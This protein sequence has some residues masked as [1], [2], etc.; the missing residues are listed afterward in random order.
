MVM[1]DTMFPERITVGDNS[2]IGF[3]TTILAHEYLIEEYRW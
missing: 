1:P 3:N 2:I